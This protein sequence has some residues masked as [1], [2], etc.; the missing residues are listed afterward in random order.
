[1]RELHP[2]RDLAVPLR[3]GLSEWRFHFVT[4][5]AALIQVVPNK[6]LLW[7]TT[8][9]DTEDCVCVCVFVCECELFERRCKPRRYCSNVVRVKGIED[10][11]V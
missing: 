6:L 9:L 5:C 8:P 2:P 10:A 4:F 1:M 7:K 11:K 3:L